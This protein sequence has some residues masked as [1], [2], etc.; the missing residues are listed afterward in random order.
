MRVRRERTAIRVTYGFKEKEPE[1]DMSKFSELSYRGQPGFDEGTVL[2]YIRGAIPVK[3]IVTRC[4]DP[5]AA[6]IPDAVAAHFGDEV[7][8]GE[9][10]LDEAGKKVGFDATVFPVVVG[11]GR[12]AEALRSIMLAHHLFQIQRIV[13]VHHSFCGT[14]SLTG[15][16]VSKV[17]KD[18]QGVDISSDYDWDSVH[19]LDYEESLKYDV[20]LVRESAGT[21][22]DVEVYGF[23]YDIDSGEL[24]EV[25]RDIPEKSAA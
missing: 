8:P 22:K 10:F 16:H 17:W 9:I 2:N 19:I 14:S 24:T 1:Q 6:G 23:F 15:D 11:G 5:R 20:R 7:Y 13:V 3:T 21:P 4:F 25:V 18:E 12:A